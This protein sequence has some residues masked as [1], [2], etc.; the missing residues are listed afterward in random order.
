M[1]EALAVADPGRMIRK[2]LRLQGDV[3]HVDNLQFPLKDYRR[4]FVIGGGKASGHMAEEVEKLLRNWITRG[5]VIIPDYLQPKPKGRRIEYQTATHPIPTRKGLEAVLAM[6]RLVENVSRDDLVIVLVSGGGSSL[7]PLPVEGIGLNDEAR[8]TS[9]LL[10]SGA[11]IEEINTVRKHL[12][13]IKGGRLAERLYPAT[14]LTLI[15]SD[16][17]G[18]R[19]DAIASGP[20]APDPTTYHDSE[21]VLKKYD[22]WSQIPETARTIITDG[23]SGSILD[24]PKRNCKV[25]KRVHNVIVGNNRPSCLAAASVLTKAGYRT[26]VL[27]IQISGEAREAGRILGSVARDIRDNGLPYPAPAAL[28]AGGETTVTVRGKGRGGRNQELALAA[29]VKISGSE[30]IVVGSFATDGIEGRTDAAG[31][32]VD[33]STITRGLK[34]GMDPDEYLRN[35]DSYRYFSKLN[36]LV[37]T[38]PTGTNVNDITILAADRR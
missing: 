27:C 1:H 13:Q 29:A 9:L 22:L 38:G 33:G 37:I 17:V 21:N 34:L 10:K 4:I 30:G 15:I 6:L 11:S 23:L 36:D 24:T 16:V 3:L 7:M 26:E 20:T 19:I 8:V 5:L 31:A 12:S 28:V 18:D 35:N 2:C 14:A 32:V 25:F